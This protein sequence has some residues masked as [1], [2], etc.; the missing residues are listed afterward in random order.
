VASTAN[1][2]CS[3]A[4][5]T[6]SVTGATTGF[7]GLTYQWYS[8]SDGITY[9]P[10]GGATGATYVTNITSAT[11][12]QR[13]IICSG[14]P[15]SQ[16]TAGLLITL[17]VPSN[18]YCVPTYTFGKTDGDLISQV[19]IPTTTLNNNTGTAAVNPAYTYFPPNPPSN[20]T[21]ASLQAGTSYNVQVTYGSFTGQ[22]CAAWVDFNGDGVFSTPSERIGFT[23][24]GSTSAFQ[25]VSFPISIPCN[26]TP[27]DYRMRI[28]DVWNTAGNTIDPC[29]NYGYGETEDYLITITPPDPCPMPSGLTLTALTATSASVSWT[30]GC[31]ETAWQAVIV[32]AGDAPGTGTPQNV[33]VTNATFGS[34]TT[35]SSYDIY[36]RADCV[37]DGFSSWLGPLNVTPNFIVPF[38]GNTS[39]GSEICGSVLYDHGGPAGNYADLADGYVVLTPAAG[40]IIRLIGTFD[41]EGGLDLIRIYDG[42]GI[43]G[44][45]LGTFSGFGS[46]DVFGLAPDAQ[47]T[48]RFNTDSSVFSTGFAINVACETPCSG[49]PNAGTTAGP[50]LACNG[51]TVALSVTGDDAFS[52]GISYEWESSPDGIGWT[53][54]GV[55]TATWNAPFTAPTTYYRR[56]MS[57]LTND[58]WSTPL[59][60]DQDV[61][62][63]CYCTTNLYTTGTSAGDLIS[64]VA[65]TGTTLAN[66]TGFVAGGPS[67]NYYPPNP[68]SNTQTAELQA[69]SSYNVNVSTG[70]WGNQGFAVWIDYNDDGVYSLTER[71][72]A[73]PGQIGSGFT[74]GSVNASASFP[75]SLACNPPLGVHRMRV[76]CVYALNGVNID[77][78]AQYTF[79]EVEEYLVDVTAPDPCPSPSGLAL[80]AVTGTS[81]SVSWNVG[82][83]E[84]AWQ[85]VIVADGAAPG[86]GTPQNTVVT[87]ASFTGLTAGTPYDIYVRANCDLNGFSSWIGPLDVTPLNIVPFNGL[88]D[89]GTS[90]CGGV[91]YDHAGLGNYAPNAGGNAVPPTGAAVLTPTAG[92]VLRLVG[93]YDVESCC[94]R[95][96]IY[97]GVGTGGAVIASYGGTG[98]FDIYATGVN[99]SV[100]VAFES[101]GSI[102]FSGFA[103][104]VTC[105]SPCTGVPAPGATTANVASTCPG[106]P[107][108]LGTTTG[109]AGLGL[110]YVWQSSTAGA[111]GP[112]TTMATTTTNTYVVPSQSVNTWYRVRVNC[113]FSGQTGVASSVGVTMNPLCYPIPSSPSSGADSD[114]TS[115]TIGTGTNTSNCTPG[116]GPG[117]LPGQYASYLNQAPLTSLVRGGTAPF[118]V[119]NG[120]CPFVFDYS[121]NVAIYLD[122]NQ[123]GVFE[124]SEE[125]FDAGVFQLSP[126]TFS[127]TLNIPVDALTG[128]TGLRV[129]CSEQ[130]ID[131]QPN[132]VFSWGEVE[133]YLVTVV[134][135]AAAND[136]IGLAQPITSGAFPTC[137]AL[138]TANLPVATDSPET[139]GVGNDV[140]YSF[141]ATTNAARIA[142]IGGAAPHDT[143]IELRDGAGVIATE[144]DNTANGSETMIVDNL[145]PNTTY[146]VGVTQLAGSATA[147][148]CVSH[149]RR[150]TCDNPATFNTPCTNYKSQ[151]TAANSYTV[152]FDD[153]GVAPFVATATSTG[154]ITTIPLSAFTTLP[155]M[156]ST[157]VYQV[158]VD[159][160]YNLPDAAGNITTAVVPGLFNCTRT[161]NAHAGVFLRDSDAS[162]NVKPANAQIAANAW[163][164]GALNY[165][166]TIEKYTAVNGVSDGLP[167]TVSGPATSRF[168][169]L[170]PLGL[171]ANGIYKV[172]VRPIFASGPGN[173]GPDR[174]LI[175][176]GPAPMILDENQAAAFE[177]NGT[178]A[179]IE[180]A[181]YPNPSNGSFVNLNITGVDANVMVRVLDGMG[182]VVWTNNL[183]VEGSLNTIIAFE[184]PLASGLYTVE[185]TYDGKVVTERLMVQK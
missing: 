38:T 36:V 175:I 67:Y 26:P 32:P 168:L 82:C 88:V 91:L 155:A 173:L 158:R 151:H 70:E 71:I 171:E 14:G 125:L 97:D 81:V 119:T 68:P 48:V 180:S 76:R 100:T 178:E 85:A 137:S 2:A 1:P 40:S 25:Q 59:Q 50:A 63:N 105:E 132:S 31:V 185:M 148:V 138:A 92:S 46:L 110:S 3:G 65:I 134:N 69:G 39:Y 182:R 112:W 149:L 62:T 33:A 140:W 102:E 20:T 124:T 181:L 54:S 74:P 86:T 156:T 22:N 34:L 64:N 150:S 117:S 143:Q 170:F 128:T 73:T 145:I 104:N 152:T 179:T 176:A 115:V 56:R 166:W 94:D 51:T 157:V 111:F 41:T 177:K 118:S 154:G 42:A 109:L 61:P 172:N 12:F 66:N 183:V 45:L 83:T 90:V 136:F 43:G 101:D 113:S 167:V 15:A 98:S 72:G 52:P 174:W 47:V 120:Q 53:P 123:N 129:I 75:I 114:I 89:L 184:R 16:T 141:V 18:C 10:I 5:F 28:R 130:N 162:P 9:L 142:V 4:N 163:L 107:I 95:L 133:D 23:T 79:G 58:A 99:T 103:I 30:T 6:L 24:A 13:E 87:N 49:T 84:T 161:V 37:V 80:G 164:C 55:T 139:N 169:N 159:A 19:T 93:T 29:L 126:F 77:P 11:Y 17:D 153:D 131:I 78:C 106:A 108:T 165:D 146:F 27:G 35:G 44:T 122:A 160:T 147:T 96:Y 116:T 135:P 57:C 121:S 8:S 60:V 21:T 144:N 7:S 127:G